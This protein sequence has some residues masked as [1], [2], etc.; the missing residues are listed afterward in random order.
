[1]SSVTFAIFRFD[2]AIEEVSHLS[3]RRI[4]DLDKRPLIYY[5]NI[6]ICNYTVY[7]GK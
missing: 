5:F 6:F 7:F 1:M 3:G 4:T 2:L